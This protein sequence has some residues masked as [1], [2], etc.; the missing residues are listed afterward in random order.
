MLHWF[1]SVWA[2]FLNKSF[3]GNDAGFFWA[4]HAWADFKVDV[5]VCFNGEVVFAHDFLWDEVVSDMNVLEAAH[6][7]V[8]VEVFY[9]K[10]KVSGSVFD[11][12]NGAVDMDFGIKDG[13]SGG[14][15]VA[16][17]VEFVAPISHADAVG[18]YFL[19]TYVTDEV[20]VSDFSVW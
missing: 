9:I 16:W 13:D 11:I 20:G 17:I 18:L 5:T 1:V 12:Q 2:E 3:E 10:A 4:V 7:R 19:W 15:R 6:G 8:E 14:G